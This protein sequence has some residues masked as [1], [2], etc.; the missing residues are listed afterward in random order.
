MTGLAGRTALVTGGGSG[1]GAAMA[2]AFAA[3]GARVWISGRM[4]ASL[5]AVAAAHE[6]IFPVVADVTDEA[7]VDRM[8]EAAGA[9]DIVVAN[10]G[11][12]ESAPFAK[13]ATEAWERMIRVNLTG[14]FLTLRRGLR[15][16]PEGGGRL[17]AVASTAGLKG[18]AYAAPYAAAKHGVVGLVRSLALEVARTPVTVNAICPGFMDTD[19]TGRS[20]A[21]IVE[22][23]GRGEQ[24]ARAVLAAANPQGRLIDPAEVAQAA[25]WLCGDGASSVNGQAISLSGGEI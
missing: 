18:Y 8:F 9:C 25:L 23:T 3:A 24:E 6:A 22:K 5:E 19:M 10:A 13:T 21:N 1:S 2:R 12:A 17:I 16:M 14:V 11:A 20:V 4:Q 7:S 15:Q